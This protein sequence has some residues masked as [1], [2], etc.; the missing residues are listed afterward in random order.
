MLPIARS[1]TGTV[2]RTTAAAVTGTAGSGRCAAREPCEPDGSR[3]SQAPAPIAI[4]ARAA[5]IRTRCGRVMFPFLQDAEDLQADAALGVAGASGSD[6][7]A[8]VM[9]LRDRLDGSA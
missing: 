8:P 1:L 6:R 2:L 5:T 3:H 7:A 4:R 9:F